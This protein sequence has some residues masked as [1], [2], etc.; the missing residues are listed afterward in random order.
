MNNATGIT[1]EERQLVASWYL[2]GAKVE[3]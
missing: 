2:A 1:P 3:P